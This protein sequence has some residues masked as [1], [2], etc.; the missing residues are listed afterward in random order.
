MT[1]ELIQWATEHHIMILLRPPH[2]TAVTQGEDVW[3]FGLFKTAYVSAKEALFTERSIVF[4]S[5]YY[6]VSLT[7][8][9]LFYIEC[10]IPMWLFKRTFQ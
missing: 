9:D 1:W 10:A 3:G 2:T 6:R 5:S 7:T 8:S 4:R